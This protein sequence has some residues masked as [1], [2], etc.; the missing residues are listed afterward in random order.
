LQ[1]VYISFKW[2]ETLKMTTGV[3][4][5][6]SYSRIDTFN[7][8]NIFVNEKDNLDNY[9]IRR[10]YWITY[11][12]PDPS[13]SNH[14]NKTLQQV[15]I[16]ISGEIEISLENK[17]GDSTTYLLNDPGK[18]LYIPP[19]YWKR[20]KYSKPCIL[21]CLVSDIYDE[22]DYIR[23]YDTFKASETI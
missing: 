1:V 9:S 12:A 3:P 11:D 2:H 16:A 22:N 10:I 19:M 7:G 5:I 6:I 13:F 17:S 8:K 18:G 21:L 4:E 20:I 15:I 14:A 23:D